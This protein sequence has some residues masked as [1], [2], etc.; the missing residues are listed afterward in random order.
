MISLFGIA[1]KFCYS[2]LK[3][4]TQ[5]NPSAQDSASFTLYVGILI[6]SW[7]YL[8]EFQVGVIVRPPPIVFNNLTELLMNKYRII[9]EQ[10]IRSDVDTTE[11][12]IKLFC[13]YFE[14][15]IDKWQRENFPYTRICDSSYVNTNANH[16]FLYL[17]NL[18][19]CFVY[20]K[21]CNSNSNCINNAKHVR[22]NLKLFHYDTTNH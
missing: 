11:I 21:T 8:Q 16:K 3:M 22:K 5:Q 19:N 15:F 4:F 7:L 13:K 9:Y 20:S 6:V 17:G 14:I 12:R 1:L 2:A 18:T 10:Q